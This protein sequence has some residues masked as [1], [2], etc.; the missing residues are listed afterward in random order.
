MEGN[1]KV[2]VV[3]NELAMHGF[4]RGAINEICPH[5]L[6]TRTAEEGLR[7]ARVHHPD[8]VVIDTDL[9]GLNGFQLLADLRQEPNLH[10]IVTSRKWSADD[11]NHA[12]QAGANDYLLKPF[13]TEELRE[14][15]QSRAFTS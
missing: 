6:L 4:V 9:S 1:L 10:I 7:L 13:F 2:L 8:V 5:P 15:I 11:R 3:D 14:K 12:I